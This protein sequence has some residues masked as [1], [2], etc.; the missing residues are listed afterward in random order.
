[1]SG[2]IVPGSTA[3]L[4]I[5][6]VFTSTEHTP[7]ALAAAARFGRD[8]EAH[9]RFLVIQAVPV[10]FSSLHHPP[11]SLEFLEQRACKMAF[12]CGDDVKIAVEV[13]LCGDSKQCIL[14]VLKP[15]SLVMVGGR[16]YWWRTREEKLASILQAHGHRVILVDRRKTTEPQITAQQIVEFGDPEFRTQRSRLA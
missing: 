8:L 14:R 6:V 10:H 5:N 7:A 4:G 2:P 9:I 13:Y 12:A 3:G 11:V 16:S 15:R 1:L